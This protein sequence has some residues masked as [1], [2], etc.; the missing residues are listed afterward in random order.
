M[1]LRNFILAAS[2]C[3]VAIPMA[4][5]F[6][7]TPAVAQSTADHTSQTQAYYYNYADKKIETINIR[8]KHRRVVSYWDGNVWVTCN[9]RVL[10]NKTGDES[11]DIPQD[12]QKLS[13]SL[14][15]KTVIKGITL[16]FTVESAGGYGSS[17]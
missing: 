9:E 7:A 1:K 11:T 8:V 6:T 16:Y 14:E 17:F 13:K 5:V 12:W 2:L 10:T 3:L 4:T 15:S